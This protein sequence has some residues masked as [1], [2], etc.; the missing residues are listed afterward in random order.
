MVRKAAEQGDAVAQYKLGVMYYDGSGVLQDYAEAVKWYR[1]AAE[2][3]HAIAQNSLGQMYDLGQG[4]PQ[5]GTGKQ[6]EVYDKF[7]PIYRKNLPVA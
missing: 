1:E 5:A 6:F 2:Q 7:N 3:G 4:V